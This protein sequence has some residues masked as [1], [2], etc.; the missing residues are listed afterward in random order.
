MN[1]TDVKE[2][3]FK[4][5]II[6]LG[7]VGLPLAYAF[8]K[9]G[10]ETIGFELNKEKVDL[11]NSG[12]SYIPDI[13]SEDIKPLINSKILKATTDLQKLEEMDVIFICVPTPFNKQKAPDLSYIESAAETIA[14]RL[15]KGQVII[16]QSTTYPGTTDEI[17][18]PIL[19]KSGLKA[20]EDFYLAFSPERIDPGNKNFNAYNTAKVVGGFDQKSGELVAEI[21]KVFMQGKDIVVV[22]STKAAEMTKI[23]ENTF[24]L[25]NIALV[26]E[27]S[28]LAD[29][30]EIN[31]WE[32]I[33][34]AAT[35]PFGFMPF[36]PGIGVGGHCIPVDP[37]YLSWKAREY[38]FFTQFI[39]IAADVNMN[40]PNFVLQKA[41]RILD[42]NFNG[43]KILVL[44][45]AFKKDIDDARNSVAI[46]LIKLLKSQGAD[47]QYNDPLVPEI[48]FNH[49]MY[50]KNHKWSLTSVE[51]TPDELKKYDL[52]IAAVNHS[53]YDFEFIANNSKKLLDAVN[54]T[55]D[56]QLDN[57]VLL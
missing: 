21:F 55:K 50:N 1:I 46:Y 20:G 14:L 2:K 31:I 10:V 53:A 7:Y 47:V 49:L 40:Q 57:V 30:M 6:G 37:F 17:V 54:G 16:L 9:G 48:N 15:K 11:L 8:A 51:I 18:K 41:R 43:A 29:R 38:D 52:V 36:Y 23:L 33:D 39:E 35:K 12:V 5:G 22:S 27:L 32:V 19:E 45:A 44:G 25:V 3:Q 13:P 34:A 4:L 28:Q 42:A 56:L 26:N 24:R